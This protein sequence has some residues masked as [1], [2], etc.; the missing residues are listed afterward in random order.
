[1]QIYFTD[2][3]NQADSEVEN[4]EVENEEMEFLDEN[5]NSIPVSGGQASVPLEAIV[6]QSVSLTNT[7]NLEY[8]L[9]LEIPETVQKIKNQGKLFDADRNNISRSII[10]CLLKSDPTKT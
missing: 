5:Q 2:Y 9:T 7:P 3:N 8:L 10:R 4:E 6:V 1:M